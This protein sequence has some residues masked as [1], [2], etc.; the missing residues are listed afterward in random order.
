VATPSGFAIYDLFATDITMS[1]PS[2]DAH[3]SCN[4][5]EAASAAAA[6]VAAADEAATLLH[7]SSE[8]PPPPNDL[9]L[10]EDDVARNG[11]RSC[12]TFNTENETQVCIV[13][14]AVRG[15]VSMVSNHQ[16]GTQSF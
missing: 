7:P 9:E 12:G 15:D 8:E 16:R 3:A 10:I 11:Y 14:Y 5:E 4:K 6:A 13:M 2:E 1:L